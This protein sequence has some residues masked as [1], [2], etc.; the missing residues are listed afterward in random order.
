MN[1][2]IEEKV[3]LKSFN[4]W[5][6][7]GE[8]DY[9][10][11]PK[12]LDEVKAAYKW[13]LDRKLPITILGGG[14]NVLISDQGI[15]GL[16]LCLK[17]FNSHR[18]CIE[19]EFFKLECDAGVSKSELLKVFLKEKLAPA[20]FLAGIPGD[21]GGG[22]IMNAGVG[23]LIQPRE[24][25]EIV[26]SFEVLKADLTIKKY[27]HSEV[28][29]N[30]RHCEGWQPGIIVKVSFS[31]RNIKDASVI[32]RV[33]QANKIRLQKQP[34]DLPSC[35]SVFVNPAGRKAAQLIDQCGL[36]GFQIGGAQVSQKHANFI[37]NLGGSTASEL[38]CVIEHVKA[39]VKTQFNLDLQTEV[40]RLGRW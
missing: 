6:V 29:W 37:V 36:K 20:E 34:L 2:K 12:S 10:C 26:E 33:R 31:V 16:V 8:A 25:N 35:G 5:Q 21:V 30:Y 32:D 39:K 28:T 3:S 4:T 18:S 13:A 23:E 9:F 11:L 27:L 7:G 38:E 19:N 22:V 17:Y 24:F 14:S 15:E 1:L 40:V